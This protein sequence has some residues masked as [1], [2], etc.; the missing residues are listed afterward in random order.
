MVNICVITTDFTKHIGDSQLLKFLVFKTV[1]SLNIGDTQNSFE[2]LLPWSSLA[3]VPKDSFSS[4]WYLRLKGYAFRQLN[5]RTPFCVLT[6]DTK[7]PH[8]YFS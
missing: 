3:C 4:T 8:T 1:S 6:L 2:S 7:V 5:R